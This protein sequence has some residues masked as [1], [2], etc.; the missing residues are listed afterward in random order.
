MYLYLHREPR[1]SYTQQIYEQIKDMILRNDLK[2]G[3]KLPS[4]RDLAQQ[5][6][7]ARNTVVTAYDMLM[8]EGFI[9]SIP[10]SGNYVSHGVNIVK[11][12]KPIQEYSITAFSASRIGK[13]I[14]HFHSGIPAL[15]DF[16]RNKWAK[17]SSNVLKEE[18]ASAF[19]Y[20]YPQ[21]LPE[22]RKALSAYLKKTRGVKCE[23]EQLLITNGNEQNII[24]ATRALLDEESVIWT[25]EIP[26]INLLKVFLYYTNNI[27]FLPMD[28]Q[29]I[30]T[31][32]LPVDN[33]PDLIYITPSHQYPMGYTLPLQRRRELIQYAQKTDSMI[34][35]DA[36]DSEF[37]HSGPLETSLHELDSEHVIYT[38][39]FA[40]LLFPSLRLGYMVLPENIYKQC[41]DCK[42]DIDHHSNVLNQLTL[43]RFIESGD[44]E[45][46]ALHMQKL[47]RQR[48]DN[49][50]K[51]LREHFGDKVT[52]WGENAG[53][54]II[55]KFQG[56]NFTPELIDRIQAAGV[57]VI[58][59]ERHTII[60]GLHT[61]EI[62]L[63][64]SHLNKEDMA[65][66]LSRLA[67]ALSDVL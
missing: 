47:Y 15:E 33:I 61:D 64:Y 62:I 22:F 52:Y 16:P 18:P 41:I 45:R 2:L 34:V 21:G 59:I 60:K 44:L 37:C 27:S 40:K 53:T 17:L 23:P 9:D 19:G 1:K 65:E 7:I 13:N 30:R 35:E 66:G 39:T 48:R 10:K 43:M 63:G 4:T 38:G 50:I 29:G 55:A 3:D 51:G 5:L 56:V 20:G 8:S 24:I 36:C 31:D 25:E 67:R 46:H 54:H 28:N 58:P 14:I 42:R 57:S 11:L 32:I 26:N 6:R 49:I 12:P